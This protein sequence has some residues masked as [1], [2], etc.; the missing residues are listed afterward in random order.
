MS[1]RNRDRRQRRAPTPERSRGTRLAPPTWEGLY[2]WKP[3]WEACQ[4]ML[5]DN[6]PIAYRERD[7]EEVMCGADAVAAIG[8]SALS[9]AHPVF[10]GTEQLLALP[11]SETDPMQ[12]LR[13]AAL[14][15]PV[16]FLDFCSARGPAEVLLF[17]GPDR[18]MVKFYGALVSEVAASQEGFVM[19]GRR[20][21]EV[22]ALLAEDRIVIPF[23]CAAR[24]M[25]DDLPSVGPG[26]WDAYSTPQN[27]DSE[28]S[29]MP[30]AAPLGVV[31]AATPADFGDRVAIV[32]GRMELSAAVDL[33]EVLYGAVNYRGFELLGCSL[34]DRVSV[35]VSKHGDC[36]YWWGGTGAILEGA[37]ADGGD[38]EA[39]ELVRKELSLEALINYAMVEHVARVLYLLSAAN[40]HVAE[41]P[42]SRQV[43][44]Q[45]E[46]SGGKIASV[47][48]VRRTQVRRP[49]PVSLTPSK[50]D[51]THR[52]ERRGHYRHVTRGPH[53]KA[54]HVAPCNRRDEHGE[55]T[56]PN[57]CRREFVPPH[58]VGDDHLPMVPKSRVVAIP[59]EHTEA[60][61]A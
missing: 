49:G 3:V 37:I 18:Y 38:K 33:G 40:V 26:T 29:P 35:P 54:D 36:G 2:G 24:Y 46:R 52:F 58:W 53:F 51:Y 34:E 43:R 1:R 19:K 47:V 30:S 50:R 9:G 23:G 44:R 61:D 4:R 59:V 31:C 17:N 41:A 5:F 16:V 45:A 10:I 27:A 6:P 60:E 8:I 15:F 20:P 48:T 14:P 57:G 39:L 7:D 25:G 11:P 22:A 13:E 21:G 28:H 56:C 32:T 42:V 12:I 55:L